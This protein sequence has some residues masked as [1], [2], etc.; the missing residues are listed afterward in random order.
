M[1][2]KNKV[3]T[4]TIDGEVKVG[5]FL[6][7]IRFPLE[8]SSSIA[9]PTTLETLSLIHGCV[10]RAIP[11]ENLSVYHPELRKDLPPLPKKPI[12]IDLHSIYKK[13]VIQGR[14]G[15]CIEM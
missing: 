15:F 11:Y 4:M 8:K 1:N 6:Q 5:D 13:I 3:R 7:R 14:G 2:Q 10:L 12:K 9:L